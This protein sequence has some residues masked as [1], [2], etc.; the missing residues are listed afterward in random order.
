[1]YKNANEFAIT[2]ITKLFNKR[3]V[4]EFFYTF[5]ILFSYLGWRIRYGI[6]MVTCPY[7]F[8]IC[9]SIFAGVSFIRK[10]NVP[11]SSNSFPGGRIVLTLLWDSVIIDKIRSRDQL[12]FLGGGGRSWIDCPISNRLGRDARAE[13][14]YPIRQ[15]NR[16]SRHIVLRES[17]LKV[18]RKSRL[19]DLCKCTPRWNL[20]GHQ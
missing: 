16:I 7:G 17:E 2:F 14:V 11:K 12:F 20:K 18:S 1:M 10:L 13:A 9:S 4:V 19:M 3:K 8:M 5:C 6:F 15:T